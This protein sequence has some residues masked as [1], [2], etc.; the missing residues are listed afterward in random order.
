MFAYKRAVL[1]ARPRFTRTGFAIAS[2]NLSVV[3]LQLMATAERHAT[4]KLLLVNM[5]M[6][7]LVLIFSY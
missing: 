1:R 2:F 7:S 3:G 6:F 5:R 4:M